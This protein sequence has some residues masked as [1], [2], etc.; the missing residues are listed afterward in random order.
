MCRMLLVTKTHH[1]RDETKGPDKLSLL[2][3]GQVKT[4]AVQS[5]V[6]LLLPV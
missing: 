3:I 5:V 6:K 2:D 4:N 1:E